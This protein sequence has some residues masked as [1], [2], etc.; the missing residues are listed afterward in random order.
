MR[1]IISSR[2]A[3]AA[4]AAMAVPLLAALWACAPAPSSVITGEVVAIH[5][6]DT[7]SVRAGGRTVRVRLACIDAP[8][9]GQA[10]G[11]RA[12]QQLA[13]EAMR[14][15]VRVEVV[16]RDNFGR[17]VGRVWADGTL[18]N[19]ELVRAGLAW[20]YARH[21]PGDR[22]LAA[23]EQVAWAARRGLWADR[24]PVPPWRWRRRR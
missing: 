14:R 10:F 18:V 13:Q 1:W 8:E 3:A 6:G 19:L 21:C 16:D 5:D 17:T 2:L 4:A 12:R 22:T 20:H 23:A 24:E 11:G 15:T 9:Q 7:L